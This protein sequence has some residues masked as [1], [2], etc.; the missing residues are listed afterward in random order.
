MGSVAARNL[1]AFLECPYGRVLLLA[2]LSIRALITSTLI[3]L[4]PTLITFA[5]FDYVPRISK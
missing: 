4:L 3:S 5:D 2:S 1:L